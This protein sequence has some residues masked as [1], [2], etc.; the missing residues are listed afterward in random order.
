MN[1]FFTWLLKTILDWIYPKIKKLIT[2]FIKDRQEKAKDDSDL[3]EAIDELKK[4]ETK[5][6]R[7][8]AAQH[9]IDNY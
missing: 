2:I 8:R 6:D 9:I 5:E 3:N 4:A 1:A 7:D